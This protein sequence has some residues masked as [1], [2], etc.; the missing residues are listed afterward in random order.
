MDRLPDRQIDR[1]LETAELDL[2]AVEAV[3]NG[4][5][6][7]AQHERVEAQW[8]GEEL[9]TQ[10]QMHMTPKPMPRP[11]YEVEPPEPRLILSCSSESVVC[12]WLV[13]FTLA[14]CLLVASAVL[15]GLSF[16]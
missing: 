13:L 7:S 4:Y 8:E 15:L 1:H 9:P 12:G 2:E 10:R 11:V 16:I 3:V 14:G 5:A 6:T